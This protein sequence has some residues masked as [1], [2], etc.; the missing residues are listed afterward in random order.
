MKHPG[1]IER[2][3]TLRDGETAVVRLREEGIWIVADEQTKGTH[4]DYE[5][6]QE[7]RPVEAFLY[8]LATAYRV[9]Y[10]KGGQPRN[11]FYELLLEGPPNLA[12]VDLD[13]NRTEM[14]AAGLG[15][16]QPLTFS[17]TPPRDV[18]NRYPLQVSTDTAGTNTTLLLDGPRRRTLAIATGVPH[19]TAEPSTATMETTADTLTDYR[20]TV[21]DPDDAGNPWDGVADLRAVNAARD[22]EYAWGGECANRM[23]A[24]GRLHEVLPSGEY[25]LRV[26]S[27]YA[28]EGF[29]FGDPAKYKVTRDPGPDRSAVFGDEEVSA[30]TCLLVSDDQATRLDLYL[31]PQL[32]RVVFQ[33]LSVYMLLGPW[34]T[35]L[36]WYTTRNLTLRAGFSPSYWVPQG[37]P[38]ANQ[39]RIG[40]D[41]SSRIQRT[42]AYTQALAFDRAAGGFWMI[43]VARIQGRY[44][45]YTLS[46]LPAKALVGI[47]RVRY[48]GADAETFYVWR[49]DAVVRTQER[50][51]VNGLYTREVSPWVPGY[52]PQNSHWYSS[53]MG[54]GI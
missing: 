12:Y 28:F 32:H 15:D 36:Y 7:V 54:A 24:P 45:V 29:A 6:E 4:P 23:G 2:R 35:I 8:D 49:R 13:Q 1:D 11:E 41:M 39:I 50:L 31:V 20:P 5:P 34:P 43:L 30:N 42:A 48:R 47:V 51:E 9:S 21:L 53:S 37:E 22:A 38:P 16:V 44:A 52:F 19:W 25:V 33:W 14:L 18:A 10:T 3:V 40:A 26:A 27:A 46:N 17:G